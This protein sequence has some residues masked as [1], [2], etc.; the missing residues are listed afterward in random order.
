M[1]PCHNL[2]QFQFLASDAAKR[3]VPLDCGVRYGP[4]EGQLLDVFGGL[5]L[6]DGNYNKL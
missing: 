6:P 5:L 4:N 1:T 3:E 2:F